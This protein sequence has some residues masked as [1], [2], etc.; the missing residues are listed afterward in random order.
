M[1][2]ICLSI[3][4]DKRDGPLLLTPPADALPTNVHYMIYRGRR[5]N[6]I[7]SWLGYIYV[8]VGSY[9]GSQQLLCLGW[10][11]SLGR[12]TCSSTIPDGPGSGHKDHSIGQFDWY[13]SLQRDSSESNHVG[14]DGKRHES[15][16]ELQTWSKLWQKSDNHG[17]HGKGF[18]HHYHTKDR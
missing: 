17:W 18:P 8:L 5:G 11:P 13:P 15:S 12:E 9:W 6:L 10:K 14:Q 3:R 1:W 4:V 16:R 2:L 7:S